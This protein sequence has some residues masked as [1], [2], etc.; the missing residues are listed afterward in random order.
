MR[1][2]RF[3]TFFDLFLIFFWRFLDV[4]W[5][6]FDEFRFFKRCFFSLCREA[7]GYFCNLPSDAYRDTWKSVIILIVVKVIKLEDDRVSVY[8]SLLCKFS[9]FLCVS[10]FSVCSF[11]SLP[12]FCI[13]TFAF[14]SQLSNKLKLRIW[15]DGSSQDAEKHSRS[16]RLCMILNLFY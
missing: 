11:V 3:L 6:F 4:F 13:T 8:I 1:L 15:S 7:L 2:L 5:R 9:L 14:C 12:V 10:R 16:R